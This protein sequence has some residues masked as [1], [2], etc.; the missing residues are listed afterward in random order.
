[1]RIRFD[2]I[3][4]FIKIYDETKYFTLFGF[5]IFDTIYD[6]TRYFLSLKS[7]ITYSF[8]HCFVEI[9]VDYFDSSPIEKILALDNVK[10]YI[11]TIMI[12]TSTTIT[13]F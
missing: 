3:D 7:S 11:K 12:K 8:S 6:R 5:E 10:I 13:C 1:M 9:K 4:G 2:K